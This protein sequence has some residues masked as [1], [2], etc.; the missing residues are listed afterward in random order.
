MYSRFMLG[1]TAFCLGPASARSQAPVPV[2]AFVHVDVVPMDRE[3]TLRDQTVLVERGRITA[4]GPAGQVVV[5]AGATHIDARGKVLIPG[6]ADMHVHLWG[7]GAKAETELFRWL[8]KGVTTVRNMD[9]GYG[10]FRFTVE[11]SQRHALLRLR[12]RSA[13]GEILAPRI[14]TGSRWRTDTTRSIAENIAAYRAAGY[15]FLKLHDED[16]CLRFACDSVLAGADSSTTAAINAM[17]LGRDSAALVRNLDSVVAAAR[18]VGLPVVGHPIPDLAYALERRFAS[19]EHLYYY[20][21]KPDHRYALADTLDIARRVAA[22]RRAEVWVCPTA[23]APDGG[24]ALEQPGDSIRIATKLAD[25]TMKALH[26]AGV[27][28]LLGTDHPD[29]RLSVH[30]ELRIMVR[31]GLTPYQALLTGTRNPA[32]YFGTPDS[33]GTIA[34]GKRAD[35]VVLDGNPLD[36]IRHTSAIAGVM[37]AGRWLPQ[38]ELTRR[39]AALADTAATPTP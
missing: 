21:D 7:G 39:L 29:E 4:L 15:D 26:D 37:V 18:R 8:A 32:T 14:Y 5:P 30:T 27:G 3:R 19:V 23:A 38:D 36:D 10:H 20:Y 34:V 28:L 9:Y 11:E 25:Y 12:A 33:T 1:L 6:L 16:L 17:H 31:A 22:T 24:A 35:L 13:A 2:T